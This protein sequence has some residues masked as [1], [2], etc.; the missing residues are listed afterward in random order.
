METCGFSFGLFLW[1]RVSVVFLYEPE[2]SVT[3]KQSTG[4]R[5]FRRVSLRAGIVSDGQTEHRRA[6]GGNPLILFWF[7]SRFCRYSLPAGSVSDG[8]TEHRRATGGNPLILF[9][10]VSMVSRFRRVS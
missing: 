6:A 5:R 3:V 9:W 1:F 10:F 8:Q 2:S 4:E 7:V